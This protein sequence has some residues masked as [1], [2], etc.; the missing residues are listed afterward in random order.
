MSYE[1]KV[2]VPGIDASDIQVDVIDN[3]V[4]LEV[5]VENGA[6]KK[7]QSFFPEKAD[8]DTLKAVLSKGYLILSVNKIQ[9]EKKSIEIVVE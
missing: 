4:S 6:V 3:T 9:K 8:P 2:L 5:R 7:I 1:W